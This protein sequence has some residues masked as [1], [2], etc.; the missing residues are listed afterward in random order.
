MASVAG[1]GSSLRS[2]GLVCAAAA[3]TA[4]HYT[5]QQQH[6]AELTTCRSCA[7]TPQATFTALACQ[8]FG[9]FV[10]CDQDRP[11]PCQYGVS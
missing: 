10:N 2:S 8:V 4:P 11:A 7:T 3:S 1:V 6:V 9:P 5:H